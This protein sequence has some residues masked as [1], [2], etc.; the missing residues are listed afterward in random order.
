MEKRTVKLTNFIKIQNSLNDLAK[1][2][3]VAK[4][5]NNKEQLEVIKGK[6]EDLKT[7]L[8]SN[9]VYFKKLDKYEVNNQIANEEN[10][11]RI[12]HLE[13]RKRE[14]KVYKSNKSYT[15]MVE[16]ADDLDTYIIKNSHKKRNFT[17]KH[18]KS[19]TVAAATLVLVGSLSACNLF[20]KNKK[21]VSKNDVTIEQQVTEDITKEEVTEVTTEAYEEIEETNDNGIILNPLEKTDNE[22]KVNKKDN[23][24]YTNNKNAGVPST[25]T[26][27][28][29][30]GGTTEKPLDP[31]TQE[32]E[33]KTSET[34]GTTIT[35]DENGNKVEKTVNPDG[36]TT[37]VT[38]IK[39]ESVKEP[40]AV[41]YPTEVIDKTGGIPEKESVDVEEREERQE[42]NTS[43]NLPIDENVNKQNNNNQST[44]QQPTTQQPTT[45]KVIYEYD[46][47]Y[48][49][50]YDGDE[51]D[52]GYSL[53][54]HM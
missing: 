40:E 43:E 8:R 25:G 5:E 50:P 12:N 17:L 32:K 48:E 4:K 33:E 30:A 53:T 51:I 45:E 26:P 23:V 42:P 39:E 47:Q 15:K 14:K 24:K 27:I 54:Y 11:E 20:K 46:E 3:E 49:T 37:K 19:I 44:T 31:H 38:T 36:T 28:I 29:P 18:W 9:A 7:L 13:A 10:Q 6:Y 41:E 35:T 1:E 2:Y 52:E 34:P 21:T 22:T 16:K